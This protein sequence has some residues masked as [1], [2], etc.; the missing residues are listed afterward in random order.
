MRLPEKSFPQR[1]KVPRS[2]EH[3]SAAHRA[4]E[5][6]TETIAETLLFS[7]SPVSCA[8]ILPRR[9][10]N[11]S[12]RQVRG[13]VRI[14]RTFFVHRPVCRRAG[15]S[16]RPYA[17]TSGSPVGGEQSLDRHSRAW[18][19]TA[20]FGTSQQSLERHAFLARRDTP[21][22]PHSAQ[23][24]HPERDRRASRRI[25]PR[26]CSGPLPLPA[27]GRGVAKRRRGAALASS[28]G[29]FRAVTS[30]EPEGVPPSSRRGRRPVAARAAA[31]EQQNS[32]GRIRMQRVSAQSCSLYPIR[33]STFSVLYSIC[34]EKRRRWAAVSSSRA[35]H[36]ATKSV[37]SAA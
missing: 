8:D 13:L 20:E 10:K 21:G 5:G 4:D 31:A 36:S 26:P 33:I 34:S 19:V 15:T 25:P 22:G 11:W 32:S 37:Q 7:P 35:S 16:R 2:A 29:W 9:G 12:V 30:P 1:G 14:R 24:C 17:E 3:C 6:G 18:N 23:R 28:G 27:S